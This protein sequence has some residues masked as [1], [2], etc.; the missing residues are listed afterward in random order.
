MG[1]IKFTKTRSRLG[2]PRVSI[3]TRG[4]IGF[5]LSATTEYGLDKYDYAILYYD[6][7]EGK[8]GIEFTN[9]KNSEGVNKLVKRKNSGVSF[10]AT[11]FMKTFKIDYSETRQYNVVYDEDS[12]LY[13]IELNNPVSGG[14]KG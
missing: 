13:V 11:A 2:D 6:K 10:S 12:G 1:F 4:Q 7:D 5:N 3:W 14:R 9:D 8:I